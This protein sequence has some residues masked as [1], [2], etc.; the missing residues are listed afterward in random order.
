MPIRMA[1]KR[2]RGR[3]ARPAV[4]VR[5]HNRE[6]PEERGCFS[7]DDSG[8]SM[9]FVAP[10]R[11]CRNRAGSIASPEYRAC[12]KDEGR[13]RSIHGLTAS[14]RTASLMVVLSRTLWAFILLRMF[15]LVS[16]DFPYD[17]PFS[18]FPPLLFSGVWFLLARFPDDMCEEMKAAVSMLIERSR[19]IRAQ[20]KFSLRIMGPIGGPMIYTSPKISRIK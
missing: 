10:I 15:R 18:P 19:G 16:P 13:W 3:D 12:L 6:T 9:L 2:P 4:R 5:V 7:P 14:V 11:S 20:S 1:K 17:R 8:C